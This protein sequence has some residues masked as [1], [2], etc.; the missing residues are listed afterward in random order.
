[1]LQRWPWMNRLVER[2]GFLWPLRD[3][4]L[5]LWV[6]L[7]GLVTAVLIT[8]VWLAGRYEASQVQA[9]QAQLVA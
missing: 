4:R 8:L 1:M 5:Y 6:A 7:V 9:V 3:R 2:W